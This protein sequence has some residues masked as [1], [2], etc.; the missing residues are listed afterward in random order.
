MFGVFKVLEPVEYV[1]FAVS[2]NVPL[3]VLNTIAPAPI[4]SS[5]VPVVAV[6]PPFASILPVNVDIPPTL[7][8][9]DTVKSLNVKL[10]PPVGVGAP[11]C[12]IYL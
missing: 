1:K 10:P 11:V 5:K 6:I 8:L 2:S 4:K 12:P 7:K 3:P 9:L